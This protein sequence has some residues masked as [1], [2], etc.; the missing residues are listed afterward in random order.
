MFAKAALAA[1]IFFRGSPGD[2]PTG[3][4]SLT[5]V[6]GAVG[7]IDLRFERSKSWALRFGTEDRVH[8]PT[9]TLA[10]DGL[11]RDQR[12]A[13]SFDKRGRDPSPVTHSRASAG[14][15]AERD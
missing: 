3:R 6:I 1:L 7:F 13:A 15:G 4:C 9:T 8:P 11:R 5:T 12:S 2:G 10:N 14:G